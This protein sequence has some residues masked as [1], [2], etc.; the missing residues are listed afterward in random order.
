LIIVNLIFA[1]V[2]L[3]EYFLL[4]EDHQT[5]CAHRMSLTKWSSQAN[6][7]IV[8]DLHRMLSKEFATVRFKISVE[9][10]SQP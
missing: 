6:K 10:N 7:S 8:F 5:F 9:K 3:K 1:K 4:N 2:F